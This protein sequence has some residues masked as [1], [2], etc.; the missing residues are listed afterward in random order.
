MTLRSPILCASSSPPPVPD[1]PLRYDP[2]P[3]VL[4]HILPDASH[5]DS[6]SNA[7]SV[8]RTKLA[9]GQPAP[10]IAARLQQALYHSLDELEQDVKDACTALADSIKTKDRQNALR[11]PID[12]MKALQRISAFQHLVIDMLSR[13][14]DSTNPAAKLEVNKSRDNIKLEP[15]DSLAPTA[16]NGNTVLSLFGNAPTQKQLFSSLQ[17][18]SRDI[19]GADASLEQLGLPNM[20][21]ATKLLPLQSNDPSSAKQVKS[22]FADVFIPSAL[23]PFNPPKPIRHSSTRTASISFVTGDAPVKPSRKSGYTLQP[24]TVGS[25]LDYGGTDTNKE[26]SSSRRKRRESV[27]SATEPVKPVED[28]SPAGL[29]AQ[30]EA[31][32]RAAYSSFAPS[33]D[34]S[35]ALVP[36]ETKDRVWWHKIGQKRFEKHFVLDPALEESGFPVAP[37]E[38]HIA[39]DGEVT[40]GSADELKEMEEAIQ[41]FDDEA[42]RP[43][44]IL[45]PT[46]EEEK[47]TK[48][49]LRTISQLIE[50]LS[51]YQR[52]RN[53]YIPSTS[54]NPTSPSPLLAANLGTISKEETNTYQ[55]LRS[56]L[57]EL[58]SQLPPYAVAKLDGEQLEDLAISKTIIIEGKEFRGTMEEDHLTRLIRSSAAMQTAAGSARPTSGNDAVPYGRTPS[59][60]G[61]SRPPP[62]YYANARTPSASLSRPQPNYNP[63]ATAPRPSY[64]NAPAYNTP[65]SRPSAY[66]QTNGQQYYGRPAGFAQQYGQSTP[67]PASQARP[68]F[69]P[70]G[71]PQ[72]QS[73]AVNNTAGMT[74][75]PYTA[76]ASYTQP[77]PTYGQA[78]PSQQRSNGPTYPPVTQPSNSGRAT[79]TGYNPQPQTPSA[80]GPSGFHSSMTSEQQQLM[81]E[82]QRAQLA[83]QPQARMAAQAAQTDANRQGSGTPQPPAAAGA[84]TNGDGRSGGTPMVA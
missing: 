30:E 39:D 63:S 35:K 44:N 53:A 12:D 42:F 73:R 22:T 3:S 11:I 67:Q 29:L 28:T 4:N 68:G 62:S 83:M 76:Q 79:P 43:P 69:Q 77:R 14:R 7:R 1:A 82:R 18:G 71:Q 59:I 36:E 46:E 52:I 60:G 61:A 50:T 17:Q 21:T 2:T 38:S 15:T 74:G 58:V 23:P 64:T 20:L 32:F 6:S 31:L 26:S 75:S 40:L 66:G 57:A 48:K 27:L 37:D 78:P 8:K 41:N 10:S 84:Q 80:L 49:A 65:A 25:W 55:S 54:R 16:Q 70:P 13:E 5:N 47:G 19:T 51:S 81:I 34:D 24:L 56:Q 9:D 45:A 33:R 72:Q